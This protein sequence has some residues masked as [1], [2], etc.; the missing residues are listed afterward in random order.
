MMEVGRFSGKDPVEGNR[1]R[2]TDGAANDHRHGA[3]RAVVA[4]DE[5]CRALV[6]APTDF[7]AHLLGVS[8]VDD[9]TI[10]EIGIRSQGTSL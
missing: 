8:K 1:T 9:F 4:F 7:K 2:T 5:D 3:E 6:R 10:T